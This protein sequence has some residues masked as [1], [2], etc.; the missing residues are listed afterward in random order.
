MLRGGE[1][2]RVRWSCDVRLVSASVEISLAFLLYLKLGERN[3]K[4]EKLKE[5]LGKMFYLCIT[6]YLLSPKEPTKGRNFV[7]LSLTFF[8][9]PQVPNIS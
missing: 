7:K 8:V 5:K 1:E 6:F 4:E 9:S 3:G 2:S